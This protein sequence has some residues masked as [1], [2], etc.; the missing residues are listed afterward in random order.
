MK[1][2]RSNNKLNQLKFFNV[3]GEKDI[4]LDFTIKGR[5]ILKRGLLAFFIAL[6]STTPQIALAD[7]IQSSKIITGTK[8]LI[9]DTTKGIGI[10]SA[11][12]GV[13][14][15]SYFLVRLQMNSDDSEAARIKQKLKQVIIVTIFTVVA[16]SLLTTILSYYK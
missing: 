6:M 8:K 16:S 12:A 2:F 4:L 10:I 5:R 13:A 9:T 11:V 1:Y 14:A 7:T 15:V 3:Q